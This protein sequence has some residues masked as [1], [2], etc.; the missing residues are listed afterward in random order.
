[1]G[2]LSLSGMGGGSVKERDLLNE[3]DDERTKEK[4]LWVDG[5]EDGLSAEMSL[6]WEHCLVRPDDALDTPGILSV[7]QIQE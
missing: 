2:S 6:E 1:M 4:A 7:D 3:K 5:A